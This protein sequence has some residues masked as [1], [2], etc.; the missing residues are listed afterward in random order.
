MDS[1]EQ[2]YLKQNDDVAILE[3]IQWTWIQIYY[4]VVRHPGEKTFERIL[5]NPKV[6]VYSAIGWTTL[7]TFV[8]N[9]VIGGTEKI[10]MNLEFPGFVA[11]DL[12]TFLFLTM[13]NVIMYLLGIGLLTLMGH[14]LAKLLGGKGSYNNLIICISALNIPIMIIIWIYY[15]LTILTG[16]NQS[17]LGIFFRLTFYFYSFS[18]VSIAIKHVEKLSLGKAVI[19]FLIPLVLTV[20]C[21]I[22]FFLNY[23][24]L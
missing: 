1:S 11:P 9:L 7:L 12:I 8:M 3:G 16:V 24:H 4:N 14:M 13:E 21:F 23:V 18:L 10:R 17:G 19:V 6:D 15:T 2:E 22:Y 5:K 20:T